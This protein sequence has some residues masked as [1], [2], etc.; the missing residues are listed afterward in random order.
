[1]TLAQLAPYYGFS[2]L[3]FSRRIPASALYRSQAH[4]EALARIAF[5][6]EQEALGL[7]TGEVGAGKTVAARAAVA[8]LDASR[9]TVIYLANPSVGARGLYHQLVLSLGGE[10]RFHTAALIPQAHE[11]L[12][13]E[14]A[15]RGKRVLIVIDEAHLLSPGQLE[16]IRLLTNAEMDSESPFAGILLGQPSLRRRLRLGSFA[17]LDQRLALRYEL[18]GM[19]PEETGAYL[20]HHLKLAGRDDAL[21]SDDAVALLHQASRGIPR[22][23]NNLAIQALVAAYADQKAIVDENSARAAVTEITAE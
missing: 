17:A 23:L 9:H 20:R 1:M 8:S 4:Q 7:L 13:H 11:L 21:F 18:P 3:P 22:A 5:V 14:R 2:R 6:I 12:T 15:E 10:P 19:S 16:E